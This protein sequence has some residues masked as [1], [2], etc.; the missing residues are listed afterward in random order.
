MTTAPS[1]AVY[2]HF[3]DFHNRY[4]LYF[5]MRTRNIAHVA[6]LYFHGLIQAAKKNME[7]MVEAIPKTATRMVKK[8]G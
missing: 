2:S 3:V 8:L 5:Q 1:R 7:R 4:T 6:K